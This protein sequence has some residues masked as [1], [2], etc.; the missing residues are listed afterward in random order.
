V[1]EGR[2]DRDITQRPDGSSEPGPVLLSASAASGRDRE[3]RRRPMPDAGDPMRDSAFRH[4]P[5]VQGT[6]PPT[7]ISIVVV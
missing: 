6:L 2:I 3:C 7:S 5:G 4:R 1:I